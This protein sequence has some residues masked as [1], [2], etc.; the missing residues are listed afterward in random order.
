[1]SG[2]IDGSWRELQDW[3]R[4]QATSIRNEARLIMVRADCLQVAIERSES[5]AAG[6]ILRDFRELNLTT[7]IDDILAVLRQ[8]LIVMITSTGGGALI[9]GIAGGIGGAGV[10]AIPGVAIGAAAGAQVGEWILVAMGL[11]ILAEYIVQD[12]PTITR[13]YRDGLRQ[14][15]LAASAPSTPQQEVQVN[16]FALQS[17]AATLA[18]G[19]V[20]MFVLLLMGIVAYLARGRGNISELA[21]NVRNSELGP[22][23]ATWMTKN[24]ERLKAEPRLRAKEAVKSD[25]PPVEAVSPRRAPA[26]KP[27]Q[28]RSAESTPP[29]RPPLRQAYV[30]EVNG[31]KG[32]AD[33][34]RNAGSTPE[35]IAR[36]MHQ[37]RR[38]LG[39][40]YKNLTPPDKLKEIYARNL[41]RYNDKLGP[42][43]DWLRAHGKSWDDIIESACRTGGKDLGF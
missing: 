12:M 42:T 24:E 26:P 34:M 32:Q 8:C 6:Q 33:R 37:A 19:H 35:Q 4:R 40:K 7:V 43:I 23:F 3:A 5:I 10:G 30:D 21:D 2:W 15:W 1:M 9:G 18:R 22:R 16:A 27:A 13:T 36:K 29:E 41:S 14:A 31:L 39:A 17:A 38:D 28:P 11:K 20:A 25:T